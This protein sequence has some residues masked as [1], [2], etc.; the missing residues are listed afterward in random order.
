MNGA[1]P[2]LQALRNGTQAAHRQLEDVTL[3]HKIMDGSLT[4]AEYRRILAWQRAV[5]EVIEP[6]VVGFTLGDYRYRPRFVSDARNAPPVLDVLPTAIGRAYVLEGASLGGSTIYRK[7]QA[8]PALAGE[9]PFAFYRDQADWGL[10]QWRSFI[11]AL[12]ASSF[13]EA[14]IQAAVKSARDTFATFAR[15]WAATTG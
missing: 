13:T 2:L 11:A 6:G 7:L 12:N 3:G 10:Q 9:A 15:Q 4:P 14:E 1:S 5:H 8:N